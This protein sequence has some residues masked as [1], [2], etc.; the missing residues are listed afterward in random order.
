MAWDQGLAER[1]R[2]VLKQHGEFSER[3]MF[4]C[5]A[6]MVNGN[7]CCGVMKTDLFL[8]LSP[9]AAAG[10]RSLPHRAIEQ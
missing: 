1:V 2:S 10:A 3:M 9:D 8:K 4:G 6:F 7:M 5:L